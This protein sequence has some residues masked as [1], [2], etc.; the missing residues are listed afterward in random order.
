RPLK[1]IVFA[2]EDTPEAAVLAQA[3]YGHPAVF[4]LEVALYRLIE[5]W[6][7]RRDVVFGC[8]NGDSAVLHVAGMLSL[9]DAAVVVT[10]RGRLLQETPQGGTMVA[11]EASEDEVR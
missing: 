8:S 11:I 4:A 3:E 1:E 7:V 5:H 10:T 2:P 9:A 6:G